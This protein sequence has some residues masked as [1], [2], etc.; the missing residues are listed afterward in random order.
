MQYGLLQVSKGTC[1]PIVVTILIVQIVLRLYMIAV[2]VW[3]QNAT[4]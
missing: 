2:C 3:V 1:R 4:A